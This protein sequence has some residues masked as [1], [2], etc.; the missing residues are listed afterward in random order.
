MPVKVVF[1]SSSSVYG[2]ENPLPFREDADVS[3][4]ISPYAATKVASEALCHSF[5]HLYDLPV[6]CLRLF[7]VYGPRQ[8]P[9]LAINKFVRLMSK[10]QPIPLYGDGSTTRDYT[11][12]DDVIAAVMKAVELDFGF[13]IVNIGS[14]R[15]VR[16]SD[17]VTALEQVMGVKAA[18]EYLPQQ[19]GDVPHTLADISR[20]R[21]L[22]DWE[23]QVS[24]QQGLSS[25]L[26]WMAKQP[27]SSVAE[28]AS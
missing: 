25:F 18:I 8:R 26:D 11:Y 2:A 27:N 14:N 16:L 28:G 4:P 5:H 19:A 12:I 23:P 3:R 13:E 24:L 21:Q 22:L 6:M 10:R 7:T 17:L 9:D 20:A 1:A 15:P